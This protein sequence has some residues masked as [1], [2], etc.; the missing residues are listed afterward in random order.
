[1]YTKTLVFTEQNVKYKNKY[2]YTSQNAAGIKGL[3]VF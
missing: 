1:M 3:K 2:K